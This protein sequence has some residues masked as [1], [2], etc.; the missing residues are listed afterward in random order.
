MGR[1]EQDPGLALDAV[2]DDPAAAM[3]A[4][5]RERVYCAFK[6][7]ERMRRSAHRYLKDFVILVATDFASTHVLFTSAHLTCNRCAAGK[8]GVVPLESETSVSA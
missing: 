4:R 3:I 2:S 8:F 1:T 5:R 6:T 7:V